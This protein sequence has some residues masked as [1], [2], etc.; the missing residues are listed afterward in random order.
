[1]DQR[2][3]IGSEL[4]NDPDQHRES[5]KWQRRYSMP[6]TREQHTLPVE[7]PTKFEYVINAKAAKALGLTVPNAML[8]AADEIIE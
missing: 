8:V 7:Q 6:R 2:R 5:L 1:M 3:V 4:G